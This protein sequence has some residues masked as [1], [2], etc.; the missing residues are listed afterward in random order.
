MTTPATLKINRAQDFSAGSA[1][2]GVGD[3]ADKLVDAYNVRFMS[4][5]MSP[6]MRKT[7]LDYLNPISGSGFQRAHRPSA[8]ADPDVPRIHDPEIAGYGHE[9]RPSQIHSSDAERSARRSQRG[10]ALGNP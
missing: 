1:N 2:G 7:L 4:G 6:F 3:P 10:P 8:A 9:T 5:Q